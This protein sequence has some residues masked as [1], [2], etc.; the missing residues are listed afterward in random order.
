[1]SPQTTLTVLTLAIALFLGLV[2]RRARGELRAWQGWGTALC[3][4]SLLALPWFL[5]DVLQAIRIPLSVSGIAALDP[6]VG[7]AALGSWVLGSVVAGLGVAFCSML[8]ADM[9]V[10][11]V[12]LEPA[13][14]SELA[15]EVEAL[16]AKGTAEAEKRRLRREFFVASGTLETLLRG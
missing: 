5:P 14:S 8:L 16:R 13:R 6:L 2:Y 4:G 12:G 3:C 1:M 15:Q 11:L 7:L 10:S 9:L